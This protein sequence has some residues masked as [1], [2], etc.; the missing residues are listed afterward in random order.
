[1]PPTTG[2]RQRDDQPELVEQIRRDHAVL[3]CCGHPSTCP[4][5]SVWCPQTSHRSG[6]RGGTYSLCWPLNGVVPVPP[7]PWPLTCGITRGGV[8][9]YPVP[10]SGGTGGTRSIPFKVELFHPMRS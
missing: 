1:M 10:D 2:T 9:P 4:W 5:V 6:P 3:L 7:V 8:V